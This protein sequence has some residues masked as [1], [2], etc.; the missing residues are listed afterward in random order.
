MLE[1]RWSSSKEPD[2]Y[3]ADARGVDCQP[4]APLKVSLAEFTPTDKGNNQ[5]SMTLDWVALGEIPEGY[6]PFVHFTVPGPYGYDKTVFQAK[7][8][9]P[10]LSDFSAPQFRQE[11]TVQ[12]PKSVEE[13]TH[14]IRVGIWDPNTGN[15]GCLPA[16]VVLLEMCL[17]RQFKSPTE[18]ETFSAI[19]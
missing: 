6:V 17:S 5:Y 18:E 8:D 3:Y 7:T 16:S 10:N 4:L 19:S 9:T 2:V 12:V 13:R 14:T 11:W 1:T 15:G